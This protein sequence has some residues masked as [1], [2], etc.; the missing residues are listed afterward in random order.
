VTV[1]S[2]DEGLLNL[3]DGRNLAYSVWG[4]P[5][6]PAVLYCHGFPT[7]RRELD[8]L[9]PKLEQ[10]AINARIVALNRPGYG[11]STF[12]VNR[13]ILD[14]PNDVAQAADQFGIG[15]F[16]ILGVS[17]GSPY[18]LAWAWA[19]PVRVVKVGIV[20]GVGPIE[21][22]GMKEA[23]AIAGP[24]GIALMRRLQF[25]AAAFS[26]RKG[27]ESRFIDKSIETM[28]TPDQQAVRV[29]DTRRWFT[30]TMRESFESGGRSVAHE[31]GLY[32]KS[33]GFDLRDI[34]ART[35]IWYGTEDHTVPP[36]VGKWL[37]ERLPNANRV[38]WP[39]HG[40]F[41]W[42]LSDQAAEIVETIAN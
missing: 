8:L 1:P 30:E 41:T 14:W 12:Q 18:A 32:R 3:D 7:N 19:L 31:A 16:S 20:A 34:G 28:G 10:H 5:G 2:V 42:M 11:A 24:S 36:S 23:A 22:T 39:Q 33:W 29:A 35:Q 9:Q 17:G 38:V 13:A 25:E 6:A 40:H 37:A 4:A 21:A 15:R 26:F 27:Q